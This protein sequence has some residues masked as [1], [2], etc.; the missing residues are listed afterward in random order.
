MPILLISRSVVF[1]AII[2]LY[3][4]LGWLNWLIGARLALLGVTALLAVSAWTTRN[5]YETKIG[6]SF[7][8]LTVAC[9]FAALGFHSFLRDFFGVTPNDKNM[10]AALF[11]SDKSE[12]LEFIQQ[13]AWPLAKHVL[14][15]MLAISV[16][17]CL[18]WRVPAVSTKQ[19][20]GS[21][22]RRG[23]WIPALALSMVFLLL[24]L[25]P[26]LRRQNP[27]LYFPKH[28]S[29]WK[30]SVESFR[31]LQALVAAAANDPG[32]VSLRYDDDQPRTVVFVLGESITR[33]NFPLAGY[34]RNTTP[35]L[36]SMGNELLWFP[37]V[38]SS[39]PSTTPSV[40][41]MLTPATIAQPHLWMTKPDVLVMAQKAGYKTFWISN[42]STDAYG[43][44]SIF[45]SH[46][47]ETV[48]ANKGGSRE[49]G[50]YDEV[51][52]PYLE[53]ALRDPAPRKF[54]VLHLLNAHPA[55]YFRYP[56]SFATFNNA[57]DA[58]TKALKVAGRSFWAINMRNY[59]DNAVRYMDHVLKRSLDLCRASGQR[60]AWIYV[61]DH[62]QDAVHNTNFSGHNFRAQS[63][64][65]TLMIFWRSPSFP[66]PAVDA[67][68][69][70][71]R[72]Y[73]TDAL[74]HTLLGLLGISGDYYDPRGD[75]FSGQF[76]KVARTIRGA[77]YP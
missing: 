72:A 36:D 40:Q 68:A 19:T 13:Q 60:L 59:Y 41:K 64:Y 55:Y 10:I 4:L 1:A 70:R 16:F 24:H 46:A 39:D 56:K 6:K 25:N 51:V 52:L 12:V 44:V 42:Q 14:C 21:P 77:P 54:I 2:V 15:S 27:V 9:F 50:S 7:V 58:V 38:L 63:Q 76:E 18:V 31:K 11:G 53:T 43:H 45:V 23:V 17:G 47:E 30:Q 28:Y 8:L 32:L 37:D 34:P 22:R 65:E 57:D 73:Q 75:I 33:L 29:D 26:P 35:E 5:G 67:G 3:V 49:E 61:P 66:A 71:V 74:D 20:G 62:G 69:L 48:L